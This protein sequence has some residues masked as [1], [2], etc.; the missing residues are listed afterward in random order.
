MA[1]PR[2][3][4]THISVTTNT[5]YKLLLTNKTMTY[6]Y[7]CSTSLKLIKKVKSKQ[8]Q[9]LDLDVLCSCLFIHF[10]KRRKQLHSKSLEMQDQLP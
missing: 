4:C 3:D 7:I 1:E 6:S 2:W 8:F 10:H 9:N 5:G